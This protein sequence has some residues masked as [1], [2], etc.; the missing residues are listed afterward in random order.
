MFLWIHLTKWLKKKG[1]TCLALVVP[2]LGSCWEHICSLLQNFCLSLADGKDTG[3]LFFPEPLQ[4]FSLFSY[5]GSSKASPKSLQRHGMST[6]VQNSLWV[7]HLRVSTDVLRVPG[8][9]EGLCS[10]HVSRLTLNPNSVPLFAVGSSAHEQPSF[11][12]LCFVGTA[13]QF[14]PWDSKGTP[15]ALGCCCYGTHIIPCT[16]CALKAG[17]NFPETKSH[18]KN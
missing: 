15:G 17:D 16:F 14:P 6:N 18:S 3:C 9:W 12:S 7:E 10:S 1:A 8:E 5:R 4:L 11:S 2:F 13:A